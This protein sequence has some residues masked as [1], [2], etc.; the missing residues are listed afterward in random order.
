MVPFG[1]DL[2]AV[3]I[4]HG[5]SNDSMRLHLKLRDPTDNM[6]ATFWSSDFGETFGKNVAEFNAMWEDCANGAAQQAAF[7]EALN[8]IADAELSWTLRPKIWKRNDGTQEVQWS[9]AAV[10]D[11]DGSDDDAA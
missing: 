1:E 11:V 5:P 9:V 6:F 3:N 8:V 4:W 2:F 10:A 7:L